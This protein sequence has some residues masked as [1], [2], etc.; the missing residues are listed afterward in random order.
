MKADIVMFN[1]DTVAAPATFED[2]KQFP[3]GI[4]YV[5]VNGHL[6][7]DSGIHTKA[8]PGKSLKSQ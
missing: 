2:P 4:D 6:V 7:I 8:L 1:P 3:S 5:I